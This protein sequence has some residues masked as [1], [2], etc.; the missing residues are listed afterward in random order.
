MTSRVRFAT[1]VSELKPS[2]GEGGW[3]GGGSDGE[4]NERGALRRWAENENRDQS[5]KCFKIYLLLCHHQAS[6]RLQTTS[7]KLSSFPLSF[8]PTQP[9]GNNCTLHFSVCWAS[10]WRRHAALLRTKGCYC[11]ADLHCAVVHGLAGPYTSL[12]LLTPQWC[13]KSKEIKSHC[14]I[15]KESI[16]K[17]SF[18][19]AWWNNFLQFITE[20]GHPEIAL[21]RSPLPLAC[22]QSHRKKQV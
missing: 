12:S 9:C 5:E 3:K 15:K 2:F 18:S 8:F 1:R 6:V 11:P 13:N 20:F 10:M 14:F 7:R 17:P 16:L 19:F 21:F 4:E 22:W